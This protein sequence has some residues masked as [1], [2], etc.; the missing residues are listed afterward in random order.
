M[1]HLDFADEIAPLAHSI[2]EANEQLEALRVEAVKVA[3]IIDQKKT[4]FEP[5]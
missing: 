5:N 3:L 2:S 4:E 1:N